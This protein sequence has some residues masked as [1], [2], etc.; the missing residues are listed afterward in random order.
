MRNYLLTGFACLGLAGSL[1]VFA[2][3]SEQNF[4]SKPVRFVIPFSAG[5]PVDV[6][7][8][9]VGQ[10]FSA[11]FGTN[12]ILDNKAGAAGIVAFDAVAK[13]NPDGYTL[14]LTSG[15]FTAIPAFIKTLPYDP[16]RDF[17]PLSMV[18]KTPGMVLAVNPSVPI[19]LVKDL[20]DYAKAN[21][22]KLNYG[23]SGFGGVQNLGMELFMRAANIKMT[24]IAY[25]GATPL[26]MDLLGGQIDIALLTPVTAIEYVKTGKLRALGFSGLKRFNK[27]PEVPTL[28]EA[29]VKGFEYILWYGFWYP[30]KVP[31]AIMNK[32]HAEIVKAANSPDV[33]KAFDDVGF[34]A[35]ASTT[36]AEFT[37]F[38]LNDLAAMKSLANQMGFVPE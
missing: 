16:V 11:N 36:S 28:D 17:K 20:V 2:Q 23:S 35:S 26:S 22:N 29:G 10:K 25:K 33:Q 14:L 8:R 27:L 1:Q 15:N 34:E 5:G 38:T 7:G 12:V 30:A 21:P 13:A 4:P 32:M 18:A 24:H 19:K 6:L 9:A 37:K 31:T 3:T